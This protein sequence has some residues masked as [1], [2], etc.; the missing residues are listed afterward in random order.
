MGRSD[1]HYESSGRARRPMEW[2]PWWK[3]V[4]IRRRQERE[5]HSIWSVPDDEVRPEDSE[6]IFLE[7]KHAEADRRSVARVRKLHRR[8]YDSHLDVES[9]Q[10]RDFPRTRCVHTWRHP[11][12]PVFRDREYGP[13]PTAQSGAA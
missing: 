9:H 8:T 12:Q 13:A 2:V 1:D 3:S 6:R 4:P 10:S 11:I 7:S 5:V